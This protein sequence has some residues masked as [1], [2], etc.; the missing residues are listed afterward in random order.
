[1]TPRTVEGV[2]RYGE[3]TREEE[4]LELVDPDFYS[5]EFVGFLNRDETQVGCLLNPR[6][7]GNG[8][9]EWRGLSF[10]GGAA[11][12][13]FICRASRE[14]TEGERKIVVGTVHDWY[15]YGRLI[16]DIDYIQRV[17]R[18][19]GESLGRPLEPEWADQADARSVLL[20]LFR[21][22][23]DPSFPEEVGSRAVDDA[24]PHPAMARAQ[25]T[26]ACHIRTHLDRVLERVGCTRQSVARRQRT[27]DLVNRLLARLVEA[28]WGARL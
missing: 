3:E 23:I 14:L 5:C 16:S 27:L 22:K 6:S 7:P 24:G 2:L 18:L 9:V 10:H 15:L 8:G 25:A 26:C 11:C 12:A 4:L 20:E 1:M 13:G 17:F 28:P 21:W 19:V